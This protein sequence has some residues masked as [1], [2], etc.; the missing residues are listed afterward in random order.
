MVDGIICLTLWILLIVGHH[1]YKIVRES[2]YR[3][4]YYRKIGW[5]TQ[6]EKLG[7][8]YNPTVNLRD[9]DLLYYIK[10]QEDKL[11]ISE[12]YRIDSSSEQVKKDI[13]E[14]LKVFQN[15]KLE[16]YFSDLLKKERRFLKLTSLEYFMFSLGC[17]LSSFVAIDYYDRNHPEF[18]DKIYSSREYTDNSNFNEHLTDFGITCYKLLL[19]TQVFLQK[20]EKFKKFDLRL[21]SDYTMSIIDRKKAGFW[22]YRG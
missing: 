5:I 9:E 20:N 22:S 14:I 18:K 10:K 12:S 16:D 21:D 1:V 2:I 4:D 7:R 17:F 13:D 15:D 6:K 8:F 3:K 11:K 19:I